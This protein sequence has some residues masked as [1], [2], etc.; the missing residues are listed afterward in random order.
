MEEIENANDFVEKLKTKMQIFNNFNSIMEKAEQDG[1]LHCAHLTISNI[2]NQ[3]VKYAAE[4]LFKRIV[5]NSLKKQ[6][7]FC[8]KIFRIKFI[9]V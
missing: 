1:Y 4:G 8:Q 7:N 6:K 5:Q 2:L 3:E 9:R